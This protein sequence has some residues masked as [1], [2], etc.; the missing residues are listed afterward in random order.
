MGATSFAK[1]FL[2]SFGMSHVIYFV[3][4]AIE[5]LFWKNCCETSAALEMNDASYVIAG[6]LP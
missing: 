5:E 4:L 6:G 3:A 1:P 2:H